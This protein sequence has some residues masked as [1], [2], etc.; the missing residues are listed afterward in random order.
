MALCAYLI[1]KFT[2]GLKWKSYYALL[3]TDTK[4]GCTKLSSN[5]AEQPAILHQRGCLHMIQIRLVDSKIMPSTFFRCNKKLNFSLYFPNPQKPSCRTVENVCSS[6]GTRS[7]LADS[8]PKTFQHPFCKLIGL[9][10]RIHPF[11][12]CTL[13]TED[14]ALSDL[15]SFRK[16]KISVHLDI[17][18]H[19]IKIMAF[20]CTTRCPPSS[21]NEARL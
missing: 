6:T 13:Y 5:R 18:M 8:S 12:Q 1:L 9:S 14:E 4:S 16:F 20:A 15:S 10:V 19:S 17:Y 2:A 21:L 11:Y 7:K 3:S